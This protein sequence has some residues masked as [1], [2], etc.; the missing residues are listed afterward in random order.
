MKLPGGFSDQVRRLLGDEGRL[1][2]D[3]LQGF[4]ALQFLLQSF[5]CINR[6]TGRR[7]SYLGAGAHFPLQI[8]T[9]QPRD[10]I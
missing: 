2:E 9:Q 5:E 7:D 1:R 10:V 8:V 3:E 4:N 6:E